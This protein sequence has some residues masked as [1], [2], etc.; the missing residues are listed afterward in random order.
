[1]VLPQAPALISCPEFLSQRSK[2]DLS[3]TSGHL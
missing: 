1:M 3:E 2:S